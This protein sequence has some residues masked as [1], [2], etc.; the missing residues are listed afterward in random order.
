MEHRWGQ[1]ER[2]DWPIRISGNTFENTVGRLRDFSL[3]GAFVE[4]NMDIRIFCRLQVATMA[5]RLVARKVVSLDAH[6]IRKE[7][8]GVGI[9]WSASAPAAYHMLIKLASRWREAQN[10]PADSRPHWL[11][12][13]RR[14]EAT[15]THQWICDDR[16]RL[17]R[18][19]HATSDST[20]VFLTDES[21]SV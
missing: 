19:S 15:A 21:A 11:S 4:M 18:V 5:S 20:I 13:A 14:E 1:R 7:Y 10:R 17:Q 12:V 2:V 6:V 8:R 16:R 3:S 9:E